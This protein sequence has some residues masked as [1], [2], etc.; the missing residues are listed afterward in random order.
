[1]TETQIEKGNVSFQTEGRLLQELGERLVAKPEV[2]LVELIKNSYDADASFCEVS[3]LGREK[4]IV[5]RDD[6]CGMSFDQFSQRWMRIA[7]ANKVQ[8][9]TS[10]K[11]KR[12]LTGQKGIGRFA[13][14]FLGRSL[15]L[16][17]VAWDEKRKAMTHLV[18]DFDWAQLDKQDNLQNARIPY[19]LLRADPSAEPGTKLTIGHL[20]GG[21]EFAQ[22]SSFRTAVLKIVSPISAL[23]GGRFRREAQE[24]YRDPGF[25]VLLPGTTEDANADVNLAEKVLAHA[26]A[27]LSIDL[28]GNNL[29][30]DI[31]FHDGQ[32][33]RR[34]HRL[35]SHIRNGLVADIRFFPRRSGVFSQSEVNGQEAW[36]WVRDNTGV[37]VVDHGFRISPYGMQDDDWLQL[38]ADSAHNERD[39]RS[40]IAQE[41]FPIPAHVKSRD[42]ANPMLSLPSNFQLVGA[43]FVESSAAGSDSDN[44]LIPAMDREGFLYNDAFEQLKDIIRGGVEFL[45]QEDRFWTQRE[46]EKKA[47]EAKRKTRADLR[48]A[49]HFIEKSPTLTRSD[50]TRLVTEY[51]GLANRLSDVEDYDREARQKLLTMSALGVVA[52]FITHEASRI[53]ASLADALKELRYLARRHPTLRQNLDEIEHAYLSLNAHLDYT[54]TFIDAT[55]KGEATEFKAAAQVRRIIEKFG[56]FAQSRGISVECDIDNSVQAPRMPI[57]VYSGVLL[58]LYTNALKAILAAENRHNSSRIVFRAE[59]VGKWHI[60]DVLDTG[61]GIPPNLRK[62]VW[63]PLFTTTSRLNNPLGSG[64]GLGLSLVKQLVEQMKG[65]ALVVDAPKGFSTCVRVQFPK[66]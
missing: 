57:A 27:R 43:V 50:K 13:V 39:W 15:K 3:S 46:A 4:T 56:P 16:D 2:A 5:I 1:M 44:V 66:G 65:R 51:T 14:R 10:A 33:K 59:N 48:A 53:V 42:D 31:A 35:T 25:K 63:D 19:R 24:K 61:I 62:R 9:R 58:N 20:K 22:S 6:G 49:V 37:A 30:Y 54:R 11:F 18:A 64:M 34:R 23:E 47:R 21:V 36:R 45:A 52:G 32:K 60:I 28:T 55:Q 41:L 7:T 26:W 8:E 29:T 38:D 17:S 12:R 40:N